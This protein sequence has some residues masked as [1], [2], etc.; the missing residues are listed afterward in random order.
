MRPTGN[1]R[2]PPT[3]RRATSKSEEEKL[4][5]LRQVLDWQ[6]SDNREFMSLLKSDFDLFAESV[7]CFTPGG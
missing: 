6:K 1:I 4:S 5:W 7:Y 3:E 2:R